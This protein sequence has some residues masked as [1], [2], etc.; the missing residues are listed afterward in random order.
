MPGVVG[1]TALAGSCAIVDA[2]QVSCWGHTEEEGYCSASLV[3]GLSGATALTVG[4][5]YA[6]AVVTGGRVQ[7]WGD[8]GFG[9]LGDGTRTDHSRP[10]EVVGIA[11]ASSISAIRSHTCAAMVDRARSSATGRSD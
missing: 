10:V 9:V 6:C 5:S 7:C 4:M 1:A 3:P 2:G 8:N 11:G